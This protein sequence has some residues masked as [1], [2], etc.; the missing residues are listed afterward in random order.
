MC[1][2]DFQ[3]VSGLSI[4]IMEYGTAHG[5]GIAILHLQRTLVV[6][7]Q[8]THHL[9][10]QPVIHILLTIPPYFSIFTCVL[11]WTH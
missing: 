10:H 9:E 5:I 6:L 11:M 3:N 7:S 2:A 1:H 4:P 8:L